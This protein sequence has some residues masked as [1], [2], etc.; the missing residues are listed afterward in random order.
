MSNQKP[1]INKK[2]N[3]I[4]IHFLS[5]EIDKF[6]D[7]YQKQK[8]NAYTLND[9]II[10]KMSIYEEDDSYDSLVYDTSISKDNLFLYKKNKKSIFFNTISS[11][12][13]FNSIKD[14]FN[15]NKQNFFL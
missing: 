14:R 10:Q 9:N 6:T 1:I 2:R 15:K 13:C 8:Y 12:N 7:K 4:D 5:K 11:Y 3:N